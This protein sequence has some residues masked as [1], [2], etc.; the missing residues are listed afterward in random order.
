LTYGD[1]VTVDGVS[2]KAETQPQRFDDGTF[3]RVPLV[4]GVGSDPANPNL[5]GLEVRW[6]AQATVI[7]RGTAPANSSESTAVWTIKRRTFTA[8]GVLTGTGTATGAWSNRAN[9]TYS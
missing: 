7:Y 1:T 4:P 5:Q 8:A 9:L 2:Y 3:C 6:D